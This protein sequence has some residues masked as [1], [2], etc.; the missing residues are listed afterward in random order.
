MTRAERTD[1]VSGLGCQLRTYTSELVRTTCSRWGKDHPIVG[2]GV[3]T[4]QRDSVLSGHG[5]DMLVIRCRPPR[6]QSRFSHSRFDLHSLCEPIVQS[7]L[8]RLDHFV[9]ATKRW[10]TKRLL[11]N[12]GSATLTVEDRALVNHGHDSEG[13][14][15]TLMQTLSLMQTVTRASRKRHSSC[16]TKE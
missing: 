1:F 16:V 9:S 5:L 10:Q 4:E 8:R 12:D 3:V 7:F 6:S 2:R 15:R 11:R 14:E 13:I